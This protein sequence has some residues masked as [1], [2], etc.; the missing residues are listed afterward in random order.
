MQSVRSEKPLKAKSPKSLNKLS[1]RNLYCASLR[2]SKIAGLLHTRQC[3]LWWLRHSSLIRVAVNLSRH[4]SSASNKI[5]ISM[6][7]PTCVSQN[8]DCFASKPAERITGPFEC[9]AWDMAR[10]WTWQ[11]EESP[12]VQQGASQERIAR[13]AGC[14]SHPYFEPKQH[15]PKQKIQSLCKLLASAF[16]VLW[17]SCV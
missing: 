15:F 12:K 9:N 2:T 1:R 5:L 14:L 4:G 8:I 13:E 17:K 7:H 16:F 3:L 11:C 6:H 10:Y